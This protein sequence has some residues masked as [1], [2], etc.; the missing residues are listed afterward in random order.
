MSRR[1]LEA[2][3]YNDVNA[4]DEVQLVLSQLKESWESI[5]KTTEANKTDDV[6]P[7]SGRKPLS[8]GRV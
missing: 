3:L 4:L 8:Y 6:P 2:N 5:A 7:E 1:L